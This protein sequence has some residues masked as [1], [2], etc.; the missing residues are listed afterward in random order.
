MTVFYLWE[1]GA[2]ETGSPLIFK[3]MAQYLVEITKP[4]AYMPPDRYIQEVSI[5]ENWDKV[6]V[7][8]GAAGGISIS[9][10]NIRIIKKL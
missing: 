8:R 4:V 9:V 3:H 6:Y 2:R 7:W 10:K 5:W 1:R